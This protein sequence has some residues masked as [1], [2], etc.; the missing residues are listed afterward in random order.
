MGAWFKNT[1]NKMN[2]LIRRIVSDNPVKI[3][4][5]CLIPTRKKIPH[6]ELGIIRV[7]KEY[8]VSQFQMTSEG[9]IFDLDGRFKNFI[10]DHNS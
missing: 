10:E 6:R 1:R 4:I 8:L 9:Y 5:Y 7:D 2:Y 3:Q